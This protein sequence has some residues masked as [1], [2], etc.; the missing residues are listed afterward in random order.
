MPQPDLPLELHQLI[1]D[2]V[3]EEAIL[4]AAPISRAEEAVRTTLQSCSFVC[5]GWH[6]H[7]VRYMFHD[8]W[9]NLF[10]TDED[11]ERYEELLRLLEVNPLI[12]RSIRRVLLSIRNNH[13]VTGEVVGNLCRKITSV[14]VLYLR[15]LGALHPPSNLLSALDGLYPLLASPHLHDL[16]ISAPHLPLRLLEI[17]PNVRSLT[18]LDVASGGS[19]GHLFK[20]H[21]EGTLCSATLEKLVVR[22]GNRVLEIIA[23]VAQG[24]PCTCFDSIKYL[25][26]TFY[27]ASP[28]PY[29]QWNTVLARWRCLET[30]IINWHI[31]GKSFC[32]SSFEDG[33]DGINAVATEYDSSFFAMCQSVPWSSFQGLRSLKYGISCQD[34]THEELS[35]EDT[36]T[37]SL[38]L[39]GPSRLPYLRHLNIT[40]CND[41]TVFGLEELDTALNSIFLHQIDQTIERRDSFP[42]LQGFHVVLECFGE[43]P[44]LQEDAL[45]KRLVER[46]PFVFADGGRRETSGWAT[47]VE[48]KVNPPF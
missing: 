46:L 23:P 27:A 22:K 6:A 31:M 9:I 15:I 40:Y 7:T 44:K 28:R 17:P 36:R 18:L 30:I 19:V 3:G 26:I 41:T 13:G 12:A 42:S 1:I 47:S 20:E 4:S 38:M 43:S 24:S 48:V 39:A 32:I 8:L 35:T 45:V 16:S 33:V 21:H 29:P 5:K 25:D 37:S 11:H 2:F 14:E 10:R 34:F